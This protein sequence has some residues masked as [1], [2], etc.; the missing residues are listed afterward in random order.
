MLMW[1]VTVLQCEFKLPGKFQAPTWNMTLT[2]PL[3]NER[4]GFDGLAD[5]AN[6]IYIYADSADTNGDGF[7][8]IP[9][10][11]AVG[12]YPGGIYLAVEGVLDTLNIPNN[13]FQVPHQSPIGFGV[14]PVALK[15]QLPD[16]INVLV[17]TTLFMMEMVSL[18]LPPQ[19]I[20][21]PKASCANP[22]SIFYDTLFFEFGSGPN[23]L[24][25]DQDVLIPGYQRVDTAY[26]YQ[27]LTT[28]D[29]VENC[30]DGFAIYTDTVQYT[31]TD[32]LDFDQIALPTVREAIAVL[33]DPAALG[34]DG[35]IE[36]FQSVTI[37]DGYIYSLISN[38]MP[39]PIHE[40]DF[41]VYTKKANGDTVTLHDQHFAQI[42]AYFHPNEIPDS[43]QTSLAGATLY[44]SLIIELQGY[45]PAT[46]GQVLTF[47]QGID[48]YVRYGFNIK[49]N[50]FNSADVV[51]RDVSQPTA[52]PFNTTTTNV[53]PATG[54]ST[55]FAISLVSAEVKDGITSIDTNRITV[56]VSNALGTDIR[57]IMHMQNFYPSLDATNHLTDTIDVPQ[58]TSVTQTMIL[59][60]YYLRSSDGSGGTIDTLRVLT[61]V[62]MGGGGVT[63][64]DLTQDSLSL[65]GSVNVAAIQFNDLSGFFDFGFNLSDQS[66]PINMPGFTGVSF[67]DVILT[68][69]VFNELEVEPGLGLVVTGI[70]GAD[71]AD[72][73]LNKDS[74]TV[75]VG[76]LGAPKQTTLR[77][78]RTAVQR[79]VDAESEAVQHFEPGESIADLFKIVPTQVLVGGAAKIDRSGLSTIT[80]GASLWGTWRVEVPFYFEVDEEGVEFMPA[81]FTKVAPVDE[82][83]RDKLVGADSIPDDSDML[84]SSRMVTTISNE[85]GLRGQLQMLVSDLKYFPFYNSVQNKVMVS[86]DL[87]DDGDVDTLDLN[88]DTLIMHPNV[89][90]FTVQLEGGT[91]DPNTGIV[92][93]GQE[94]LVTF[95]NSADFNIL[96]TSPDSTFGTFIHHQFALLD[97]FLLARAGEQPFTSVGE[98][99]QI[100]NIP[101]PT[102]SDTLYELILSP[103]N[104]ELLLIYDVSPYG[105]LGWLLADREHYIATKFRLESTPNPALLTAGAGIRVSSYIEF[106]L[107]SGP[108]LGQ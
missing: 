97:T 48:P 108:L 87:N 95:E 52:L 83:T 57:M 27:N 21:V 79:T 99:L 46:S 106:I 43:I 32:T 11:S 101:V 96:D 74:V 8:D 7:M 54:D 60:G 67:A 10:D 26:I 24:N 84:Q 17:D 18:G 40:Y 36:S 62:I 30:G 14:P 105:E 5:S 102:V 94:G 38:Q 93:E 64:L 65:D 39:V 90:L 22:D 25:R 80:M 70:N 59:N 12:N 92:L 68:L 19:L 89:P 35:A 41:R 20:P 85:S 81:Q 33:P 9:V 28:P 58:N 49:I 56:S 2:M 29:W 98:A 3:I 61:E 100:T 63:S 103:D 69:D 4:Y 42:S 6:F 34:E 13:I 16:S 88:L 73:T 75:A 1:L 15:E 44:D 104:N 45:I 72:V 91:V 37:G 66:I 55:A 77:I 51:F 78:N 86:A 23:D 76:D 71:T 47:L 107:K 82:G 31:V 53:D 50:Q